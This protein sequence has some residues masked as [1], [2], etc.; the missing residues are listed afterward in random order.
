MLCALLF[1]VAI[2]LV[3]GLAA[4]DQ[5]RLTVDNRN[6]KQLQLYLSGPAYYSF[7]IAGEEKVIFAVNRGVYDYTITGC[8]RI[9]KGTLDL[10]VNKTLV[11]KECGTSS[12][13]LAKEPNRVDLG[14]VLKVVKIKVE[15]LA[16]GNSLVILT[17]PS[18]YVFSLKEDASTSYTVAKGKYEVQIFACG[19]SYKTT[20][21]ATKGYKLNVRC[22]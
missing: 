8:G 22:P 9:A 4:S 17:G 19:G 10:S 7:K 21:E 16:T 20:F 14:Q 12:A 18:T 1:S 13:S 15:N 11:M 2:P 6:P 5:V 3:A